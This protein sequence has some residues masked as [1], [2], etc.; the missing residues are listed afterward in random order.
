MLC[1]KNHSPDHHFFHWGHFL[2][3]VINDIRTLS[4]FYSTIQ[5]HIIIQGL[6]T[7]FNTRFY[8]VITQH[9]STTPSSQRKK[10][11]KKKIFCM[12]QYSQSSPETTS[13]ELPKNPQFCSAMTNGKI[14][15]ESI[16]GNALFATAIC[17]IK[18]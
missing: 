16:R 18:S 4:A 12:S 14:N 7:L 9:C 15:Q 8:E 11:E 13:H 17:I 10:K 3:K 6:S 1:H 5:L 2:L